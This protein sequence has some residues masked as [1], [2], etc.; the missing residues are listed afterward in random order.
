MARSA[1]RD[2]TA[3]NPDDHRGGA[4]C[5]GGAEDAPATGLGSL[6]PVGGVPG[7]RSPRWPT[8]TGARTRSRS[9][10]PRRGL[11]CRTWCRSATTGCSRH[12]SRSCAASAAVMAADLAQAPEHRDPGAVLRGRAPRELRGVRDAERNLVFDLNDFDETHA[13]PSSGMSS[14]SPPASWSPAATGGIP[15]AVV[16]E[17]AARALEATAAGSQD[18]GRDCRSSEAWYHRSDWPG[19]SPRSRSPEMR[20]RGQRRHPGARADGG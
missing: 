16:A 3:W 15:T 6:G 17:R 13:D 5:R 18:A 9:W 12:P 2:G 4:S 14:G 7:H 1:S 11:G 8:A 20:Q 19:S 10:R